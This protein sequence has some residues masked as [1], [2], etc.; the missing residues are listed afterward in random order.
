M[1][2]CV[3]LTGDKHALRK[4]DWKSIFREMLRSEMERVQY[5]TAPHRCAARMMREVEAYGSTKLSTEQEWLTRA[6]HSHKVIRR[7]LRARKGNKVL[8]TL[9][10]FFAQL[11]LYQTQLVLTHNGGR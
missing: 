3:W 1:V 6:V 10:L 2:E 11:V 5:S 7:A 8:H 4:D 9:D